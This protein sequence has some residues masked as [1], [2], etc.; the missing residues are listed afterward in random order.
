[1]DELLSEKEQIEEIRKW[2]KEN[3]TWV[4]GGL[5][6]GV[7]ILVG[8]NQ[9]QSHVNTKAEQASALYEEARAAAEAGDADKVAKRAQTLV[10]EYAST[11]YDE[12]ASMVLAK[13]MVEQGRLDEAGSALEYVIQGKSDPQLVLVARAR[14]AQ[15]RMQQGRH[16]EALAA[17]EVENVGAFGARY[18]ELRGD[19]AVSRGDIATARSEY[20]SAL[21]V[22]DAGP[23]NRELVGIKLNDL[24]QVEM[25]APAEAEAQ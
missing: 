16:D 15:V 1:M 18:S 21:S 12:Q 6:L 17:L 11:P 4:L 9:W 13:A 23:V 10:A 3:G 19:I 8:W 5:V 25:A 2:W 24:P 7:S 14:L 22:L 20:E